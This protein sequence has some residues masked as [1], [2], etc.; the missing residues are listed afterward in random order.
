ME[1]VTSPLLSVIVPVYNVEEYLPCCIDSI[2]SQTFTNFEVLLVDDGSP[3]KCGEICDKYA[4]R[5]NRIVVFHQKNCGVSGAR[6]TGLINAR[7]V[8]ITFVDPD[9]ALGENITYE[10]N[11]QILQSNPDIDILQYPTYHKYGT[12][13]AYIKQISSEYIIGKE[14][15]FVNWYSSPGKITHGLW[16]KI[17]KR[18]IIENIRFPIGKVYEDAYVVS[19]LISLTNCVYLS[20]EGLYLYYVRNESIT[21]KDFP[22]NKQIDYL[23]FHIKLYLY[24]LK[25]KKIK[26]EKILLFLKIYSVYESIGLSNNVWL[27]AQYLV[28]KNNIPSYAL[29]FSSILKLKAIYIL[30]ILVMKIIGLHNYHLIYRLLY[31]KNHNIR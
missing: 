23:D 18:T 6:N 19:D 1:K 20:T 31:K 22:I 4:E 7:G 27:D 11:I 26:K 21:H 2:L 29:L 16:N 25:L 5:D 9:D 15:L 8:Y 13:E 12:A 17:F 28:I 24:S 14:N 10:K 30:K 3:D